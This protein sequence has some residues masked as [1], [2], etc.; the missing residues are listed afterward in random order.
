[1]NILSIETS[2]DDTSIAIIRASGRKRVSFN[3]L[4]NIISSQIEIHKKWGG[5]YPSLAK[6]E[7]KNNLIPVF[8]KSLKRAGFL[9]KKET[10]IQKKREIEKILEREP[11]LL[12][13]FFKEIPRI[14]KPDIDFIAVTQ[15]PG[16]EPCLWVGLNFAKALASY[17][18]I[19]I[20]PVNHIKGHIYSSFLNK[21]TNLEKVFPAV[22]LIVSGGHTQLIH[23]KD[24]KSY[25]IIG[26]TRDDAAGE[27]L[28][29]IARILGLEYPGGP[30]IE[31]IAS[32]Y[33]EKWSKEKIVLPR[34]MI[35][36]KNYDFSFSGLKTAALYDFKKRNKK[37]QKDKLYIRQMCFQAQQSIIDVLIHKTIKA[38]Q[39]LKVKSIILGGGVTANKELKKQM[40]KRIKE[41]SPDLN[42]I[43]SEKEF[44]TDNAAMTAAA[45]YFHYL[46]K[47][48]EDKKIIKA[49]ANLRIKR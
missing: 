34:P 17:W 32:E 1:M 44:C 21:K 35:Y 20:I 37:T 15:G 24:Y 14:K 41:I 38:T 39:N 30:I 18:E 13:N 19:P 26:E 4:S 27:C 11:E 36:A 49:K 3:I 7:H 23:M 40:K 29:K 46:Q 10:E 6:R 47:G 48:I 22:C 33:K 5:V 42:F 28:D 2:C 16:L 45:A 9:E 43:S 8:K 12:K 25:K 31:K